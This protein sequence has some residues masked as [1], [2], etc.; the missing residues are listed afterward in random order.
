MKMDSGS[1]G[2]EIKTKK[3][4]YSK[5][6]ESVPSDSLGFRANIGADIID[7]RNI[8]RMQIRNK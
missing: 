1:E 5:K 3:K 4:K 2:E 7:P 6:G 8:R